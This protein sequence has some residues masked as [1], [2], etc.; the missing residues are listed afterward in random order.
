MTDTIDPDMADITGPAGD[1]AELR[2]PGLWAALGEALPAERSALIQSHLTALGSPE[3]IRRAVDGY[4]LELREFSTLLKAGRSEVLQ[5][6]END[7]A[8]AALAGFSQALPVDLTNYAELVQCVRPNLEHLPALAAAAESIRA[9]L[10]ED[11]RFELTVDSEEYEDN[12]HLSLYVRQ[13]RYHPDI[14][15]IIDAALSQHQA[16]LDLI[17]PDPHIMTDFRRPSRARGRRSVVS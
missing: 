4:L 2:G 12:P 10:G 17:R 15:Q 6:L 14:C 5:D 11:L 8:R 13:E 9:A 16:G 3:A 1:A 7:A